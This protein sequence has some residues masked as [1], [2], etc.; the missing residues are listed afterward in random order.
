MRT[1]REVL[2]A[3]L[4]SRVQAAEKVRQQFADRV[5]KN[6]V[7]DALG[8]SLQ[9][10]RDDQLGRTSAEYLPAVKDE[11]KP[12]SEV[13]EIL[14]GRINRESSYI[15]LGNTQMDLV[16]NVSR[17]QALNELH[18]LVSSFIEYASRQK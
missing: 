7:A 3:S 13:V 4:E 18:E 8:W 12:L 10:L 16:G 14:Q 11:S 6:G 1:N 5:I 9:Y 15:S 2:V 17:I